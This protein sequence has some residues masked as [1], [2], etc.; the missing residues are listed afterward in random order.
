MHFDIALRNMD[1]WIRKFHDEWLSVPYFK[2][3]KAVM[4]SATLV[5]WGVYS[6]QHCKESRGLEYSN[7]DYDVDYVDERLFQYVSWCVYWKHLYSSRRFYALFVLF[8]AIVMFIPIYWQTISI[9]TLMV[10]MVTWQRSY[11]MTT[12]ESAHNK[13]KDYEKI[14]KVHRRLNNSQGK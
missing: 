3:R 9:V 1:P 10:V 6:K 2:K 11:P 8:V 5:V 14:I 13:L 7:T 12:A 4:Q